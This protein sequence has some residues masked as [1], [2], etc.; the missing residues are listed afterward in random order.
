MSKTA[1]NSWRGAH[2]SLWLTSLLQG[3]MCDP[4]LTAWGKVH[5]YPG[6]SRG[7]AWAILFPPLGNGEFAT[8]TGEE[9]AGQGWWGMDGMRWVGAGMM[10]WRSPVLCY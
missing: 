8:L 2:I 3:R 5:F 6:R 1:I 10:I 9:G 4:P 7:L